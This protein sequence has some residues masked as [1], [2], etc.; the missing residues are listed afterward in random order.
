M[1]L[2]NFWYNGEG[3]AEGIEDVQG[4]VG[5]MF[6]GHGGNSFRGKVYDQYIDELTEGKYSLYNDLASDEVKVID[7]ILQKTPFQKIKDFDE[8]MTEERWTAFV[9]M[10]NIHA[11]KGHSLKAWF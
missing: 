9:K 2:D 6:S 3:L 4:V 1:G 5:G 7:A 11:E 10:W 8:D